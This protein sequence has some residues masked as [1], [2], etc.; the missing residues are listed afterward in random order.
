[1]VTTTTKT[2]NYSIIRGNHTNSVNATITSTPGVNINYFAKFPGILKLIELVSPVKLNKA[3]LLRLILHANWWR[4]LLVS[5]LLTI[6]TLSVRR[7]PLRGEQKS[8]LFEKY[9]KDRFS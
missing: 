8:S 2:L 5:L 7:Q 1:M 9:K 4:S 3:L 6:I